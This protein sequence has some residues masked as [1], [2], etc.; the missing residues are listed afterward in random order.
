[1]CVG[2]VCVCGGGGREAIDTVG[3]AVGAS[4]TARCY[5]L[6]WSRVCVLCAMSAGRHQ[7]QLRSTGE[8]GGHRAGGVHKRRMQRGGARPR[9][10]A[11][12]A[13]SHCEQGP[14]VPTPP[15]SFVSPPPQPCVPLSCTSRPC[16][17]APGV[18][19]QRHP[20]TLPPTHPSQTAPP[21]STFRPR[22]P[23]PPWAVT[24]TGGCRGLGRGAACVHGRVGSGE[25]S[26]LLSAVEPVLCRGCGCVLPRAHGH[27]RSWE[28]F[29]RHPTSTYVHQLVTWTGLCAWRPSPCPPHTH[30]LCAGRLQRR[31]VAGRVRKRG[32]PRAAIHRGG[33]VAV[34]GGNLGGSGSRP[35]VLLQSRQHRR[36][37]HVP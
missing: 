15:P 5:S 8:G 24:H 2:Y 32:A 34:R 23:P 26:A 19:V 4:W 11:H 35:H 28:C 25:L 10:Q 37:S 6:R 27:C 36:C 29:W 13:A 16:Y 33:H 22:L 30:T 9:P 12:R 1:M 31:A 18:A 3:G 20:P 14:P 21:P 7:A 17:G